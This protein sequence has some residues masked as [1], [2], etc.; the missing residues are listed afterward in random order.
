MLK[1]GAAQG[2]DAQLT[3]FVAGEGEAA[4]TARLHGQDISFT[5][6]QTGGHWGPN[7]MA[8]LLALGAMDVDL[9]TGLKALKSFAAIEGR[10]AEQRLDLG[11]G[12]F[13]LI[14]ESYNANPLSM[15]ATLR[16]L[17]ARQGR[18]IAV[19]TDMLELGPDA[20]RHHA[21]LAAELESADVQL[22]FCAGPLMRS[23]WDALPTKRKGAYAETAQALAPRVV[24][25]VQPGDF[26]MVKGSNGSKASLVVRALVD[27]AAGGMR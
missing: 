11:R 12:A 5:I 15:R 25:A 22:V 3:S 27:A 4:V 20:A 24:E 26:V 2:A 7:S 13:T 19:L 14:D 10:G 23:L 1:F 6:P 21:T 16:S 18:R 8:V 17:G 9:A